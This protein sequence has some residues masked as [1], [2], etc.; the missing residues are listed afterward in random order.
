MTP[1]GVRSIRRSIEIAMTKETDM[2]QKKRKERER[3]ES[4]PAVSLAREEIVVDGRRWR[5]VDAPR[6][7]QPKSPGQRLTGTYVGKHTKHGVYG[8]YEVVLIRDVVGHVWDISGAAINNLANAIEVGVDVH[9]VFQ[10]SESWASDPDKTYNV[11]EMYVAHD[12]RRV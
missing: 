7:W 4:K 5:R 12:G 1:H 8:P 3:E 10:G 11:Y 2:G 9:I 6:S